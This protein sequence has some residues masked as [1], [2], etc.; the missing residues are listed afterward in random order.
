[1]ESMV[2]RRAP[3]IGL[4]S[5]PPKRKRPAGPL[6]GTAAPWKRGRDPIYIT[7]EDRQSPAEIHATEA[8]PHKPTTMP[9]SSDSR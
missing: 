6:N 3:E 9:K 7:C 2:T 4:S 5:L 8:Q 1:M